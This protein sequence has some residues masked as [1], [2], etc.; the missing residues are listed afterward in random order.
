MSITNLDANLAA[1]VHRYAVEV[2][3]AE[4][5]HAAA[6]VASAAKQMRDC[7]RDGV[8]AGNA[9]VAL[10]DAIAALADAKAK[11]DRYEARRKG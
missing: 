5:A 2:M 7:N 4:V 1:R 11:L 9:P 3:L 6:E 10:H 8:L